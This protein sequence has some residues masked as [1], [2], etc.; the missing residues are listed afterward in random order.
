MTGDL[1]SRLVRRIEQAYDR[2]VATHRARGVDEPQAHALALAY[3]KRLLAEALAELEHRGLYP[4][5]DEAPN[6]AGHH[7]R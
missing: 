6:A 1:Q 7:A 5:Q 2:A 4:F 3:A